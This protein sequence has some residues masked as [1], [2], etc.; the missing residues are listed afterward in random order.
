MRADRAVEPKVGKQYRHLPAFGAV[1]GKSAL[2]G[3]GCL[4]V[5]GRPGSGRIGA[6]SSDG[7]VQ[8]AAMS[9]NPR[10]KGCITGAVIRGVAGHYA[11]RQDG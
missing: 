10:A 1:F 9:N 8:L 5:A 3:W 6:Q 2:G 7:I 4:Q 11:V